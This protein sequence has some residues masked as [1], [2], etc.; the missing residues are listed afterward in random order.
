M[1][2]QIVIDKNKCVGCRT[3]EL[4]CSFQKNKDFNPVNSNIKIYLDD[5]GNLE[6]KVNLQCDCSY[7]LLPLCVELCPL[8]AMSLESY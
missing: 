4:S 3:C 5:D 2:A 7:A 6:I 1:K 8:K